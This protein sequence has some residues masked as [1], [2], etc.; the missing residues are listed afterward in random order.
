MRALRPAA[1]AAVAALC[2]TI[3]AAASIGLLSTRKPRS[4]VG[5]PATSFSTFQGMG[6]GEFYQRFAIT[7][8]CTKLVL[9]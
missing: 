3:F 9:G 7:R 2:L 1:L 8:C 5:I 4:N 6:W